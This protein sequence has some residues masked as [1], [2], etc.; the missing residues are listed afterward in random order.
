LAIPFPLPAC[1]LDIAGLSSVGYSHSVLLMPRAVARFAKIE[2]ST[3]ARARRKSYRLNGRWPVRPS[4]SPLE[5]NRIAQRLTPAE[6]AVFL[7]HDVFAARHARGG[8]PPRTQTSG[9][10]ARSSSTRSAYWSGSQPRASRSRLR[11]CARILRAIPLGIPSQ[12][13]ANQRA[14]VSV[15]L[16]QMTASV[17]LIKALGGGW[18]VS[19][20]PKQ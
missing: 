11:G 7:L 3:V 4:F 14:A 8:R 15:R 16:G 12:L 6:R 5:I 9:S 17:L 2:L 19:R 18:D 10:C 13:L 20:L 1:S